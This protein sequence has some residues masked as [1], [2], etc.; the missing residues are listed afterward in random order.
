MVELRN[1][2]TTVSLGLNSFRSL[3][4]RTMAMPLFNSLQIRQSLQIGLPV[5]LLLGLWAPVPALA[6][7]V[8]QVG[9][10]DSTPQLEQARPEAAG[11]FNIATGQQLVT[12][13]EAAIAN[14]N[15]TTAV[16]KLTQARQVF[17]QLSNYYSDLSGVFSGIDNRLRDSNRAQALEAA[18]LRDATSYQLASVYQAQDTLDLAIPLL[19]EVINSQQ[20]TRELGEQ[21]FTKLCEIGF[22]NCAEQTETTGNYNVSAGQQLMA[23]AEGAIAVQ[24]YAVALEKLNAAR[25]MFN[26]LSDHYQ[27][28]SQAFIGIDGEVSESSR[29]QALESA[30]LR[31]ETSYQMALIHRNQGSP[32]RSIPLLIEV[33]RSQQPTRDLGQQA[34][35][36]LFELG[37]VDSP[38]PSRSSRA[39]R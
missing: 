9:S 22:T 33:V 36:Q 16:S 29:S 24:N 4:I 27:S 10:Q 26:A 2:S 14:Q 21:A 20:P 25:D 6:Q 19:I 15:Y 11:T 38:F 3:F 39:N 35:Q 17:E 7:V 1:V 23:E 18:E 12:E 5:G 30:Q 31:D 28:L 32:E 37:F 34:Y 13:A 8:S